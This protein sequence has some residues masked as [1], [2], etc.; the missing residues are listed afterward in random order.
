MA[1]NL[2]VCL[3]IPLPYARVSSSPTLN[4]QERFAKKP[5]DL[6]NFPAVNV[7]KGSGMSSPHGN[8][9]GS[10]VFVL[11]LTRKATRS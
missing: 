4:G 3:G 1:K 10:P 2:A 11:S 6:S 7:G 8:E 5:L 9:P